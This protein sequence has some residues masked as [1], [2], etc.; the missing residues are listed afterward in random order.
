AREHRE[1]FMAYVLERAER[2]HRNH[3]GHLYEQWLAWNDAYFDGRLICPYLLFAE[4]STP[5]K[6]GDYSKTSCFGGYGQIRLR[7][8]LVD[9]RHRLLR[10]GPQFAEGRRRYLADVCLHETVHQAADE[11]HHNLEES[12]K[13]HGALFASECNR[14][15]RALGLPPVR[16]AKARGKTRDLP[17]CAQWPHNVRPADYY[18]GALAVPQGK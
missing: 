3:L 18:L 4:P 11:V 15:G 17:S 10:P 12:Y 14:I 7:P 5:W 2:W 1:A 8:S 9:G 16:A 6:L 13:G